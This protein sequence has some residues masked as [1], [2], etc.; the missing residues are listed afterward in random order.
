MEVYFLPW[1]PQTGK[2][3]AETTYI[4]I[5]LKQGDFKQRSNMI[6]CTLPRRHW[7]LG[8]KVCEGKNRSRDHREGLD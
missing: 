5:L 8:R 6:W 4:Q 2:V 3:R 1:N 7:L